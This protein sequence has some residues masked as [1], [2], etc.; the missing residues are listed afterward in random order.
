MPNDLKC[1]HCGFTIDEDKNDLWDYDQGENDYDCPNC[2][3]ELVLEVELV[4]EYSLSK[5]DC[6]DDEHDF[7]PWQ[8]TDID[9]HTLE[10]WRIE[11]RVLCEEYKKGP[12]SWFSRKCTECDEEQYSIDYPYMAEVEQDDVEPRFKK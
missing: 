4:R 9:K 12:Y 8:R 1:P 6:E 11:S 5:K 2:E 3:K 7:G 10:R